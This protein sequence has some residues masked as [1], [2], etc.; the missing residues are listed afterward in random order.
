MYVPFTP[1]QSDPTT[2]RVELCLEFVVSATRIRREA[3]GYLLGTHKNFEFR[4]T[5]LGLAVPDKLLVTI[6]R[7]PDA[8][9]PSSVLTISGEE[10]DRGNRWW[11]EGQEEFGLHP[12]CSM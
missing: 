10:R 6:V 5:T 2:Y 3:I 8:K 1:C 11:R 12:S 9:P 4:K 7:D